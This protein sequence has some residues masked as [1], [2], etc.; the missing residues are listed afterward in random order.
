MQSSLEAASYAGLD[1]IGALEVLEQL[2]GT[3]HGDVMNLAAVGKLP[4]Y[5]DGVQNEMKG[6]MIT[7]LV[8]RTTMGIDACV[9]AV[10]SGDVGNEKI[11]PG[12]SSI[13]GSIAGESGQGLAGVAPLVLSL[14][15]IH[16]LSEGVKAVQKSL[17]Q[18]MTN[19][20]T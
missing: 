8:E 7:D 12:A 20:L 5:M 9:G 19:L 17:H 4:E 6:I 3:C 1:Y 18:D 15:R 13:N 11:H 2:E 10:L 14:C 16:R